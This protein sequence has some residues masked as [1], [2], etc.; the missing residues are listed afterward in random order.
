MYDSWGFFICSNT[1]VV[2]TSLPNDIFR[3][4]VYKSCDIQLKTV[5]SIGL[6]EISGRVGGAWPLYSP[7]P[8]TGLELTTD[9]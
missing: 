8:W 7:K 4:W 6:S 1:R 5:R 3:S 9:T 2:G